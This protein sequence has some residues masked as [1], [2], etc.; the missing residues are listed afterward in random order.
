[1]L[2]FNSLEVFADEVLF[3]LEPTTAPPLPVDPNDLSLATDSGKELGG[4]A[5]PNM[6]GRENVTWR[7]VTTIHG[8]VISTCRSARMR[9]RLLRCLS[10]HV[11]VCYTG[12]VY[13][14]R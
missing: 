2:V 13:V 3:L 14:E 6:H 7:G 9:I 5:I 8:I 10:L 4:T 1:M 12:E 11:H